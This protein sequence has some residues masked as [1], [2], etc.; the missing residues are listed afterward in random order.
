MPVKTWCETRMNMFIQ[1]ERVAEKSLAD[2]WE[3]FARDDGFLVKG[4]DEGLIDIGGS[5]RTNPV[6]IDLTQLDDD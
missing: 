4:E 5:G 6:F 3:K 1:A 2:E